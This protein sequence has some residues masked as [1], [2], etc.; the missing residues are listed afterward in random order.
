MENPHAT[1]S[2]KV[3]AFC[4]LTNNKIY[5]LF[6]FVQ[7]TVTRIIY[8]DVLENQLLPQLNED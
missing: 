6:L 1:D 5:S 2:T 7:K 4:A 3:T 8:L